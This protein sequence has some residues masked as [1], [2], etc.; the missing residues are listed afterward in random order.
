MIVRELIAHLQNFDP[1]LPVIISKDEIMCNG[2][3]ALGDVETVE[4]ENGREYSAVF[5]FPDTLCCW[6]I[7]KLLEKRKEN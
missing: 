7:D 5:L 6:G 1:E 3:A 4:D 2:L